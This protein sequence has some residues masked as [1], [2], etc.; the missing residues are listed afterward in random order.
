MRGGVFALHLPGRQRPAAKRLGPVRPPAPVRVECHHLELRPLLVNGDQPDAA[1][2][3]DV[4]LE[5]RD[6]AL[7]VLLEVREQAFDERVTRG[8][9]V[10]GLVFDRIL[11]IE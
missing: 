5:P 9:E 7:R 2:A 1:L 8:E 3:R 11:A 6:A 10:D 4:Q